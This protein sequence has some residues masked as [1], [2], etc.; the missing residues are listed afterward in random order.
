MRAGSEDAPG[1]DA[2]GLHPVRWL[3]VGIGIF[4]AALLYGD[5][6]ITP[7][8]SVLS[9]V[10]GLGTA[11]PIFHKAVAPLTIVILVGLFFFQKRGTGRVG[12]VFGPVTFLW[13]VT[14]N[15]ALADGSLDKVAG[16][17]DNRIRTPTPQ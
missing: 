13:F 16:G 8:I 9:A 17:D 4:G 3:L 11:T 2:H 15:Q 10:E 12:A 5:A 6:I 14:I 1:L 7:A